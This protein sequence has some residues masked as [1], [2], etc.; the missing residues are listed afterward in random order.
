MNANRQMLMAALRHSAVTLA[1]EAIWFADLLE[2]AEAEEVGHPT[3]AERPPEAETMSTEEYLAALKMLGLNTAKAAATMGVSVRRAYDYQ[4][5]DEVPKTVVKL[6]RA[7]LRHG[8]P[9]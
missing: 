9:Q 6:L 8:L 1:R 5:G 4:Q 2:R 3:D 7:Y